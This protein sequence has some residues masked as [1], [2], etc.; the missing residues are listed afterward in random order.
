MLR[1]SLAGDLY[2]HLDNKKSNLH[3]LLPTTQTNTSTVMDLAL[4]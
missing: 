3:G 2:S 1:V 4:I